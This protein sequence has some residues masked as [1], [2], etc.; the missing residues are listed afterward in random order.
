MFEVLE[1]Y[2]VNL[3]QAAATGVVN[4]GASYA[5]YSEYTTGFSVGDLLKVGAI[6]A[7]SEAIAAVT[8]NQ[9]LPTLA[10]MSTADGNTLRMY[11]GPLLSGL[12]YGVATNSVMQGIDERPFF[13]KFLFQA[14]SSVLAGYF[15]VPAYKKLEGPKYS[16]M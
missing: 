14:G 13:E 1:Q 15:T 12:I 3:L 4:Y 5:M 10:E 9:L 16:S 2:G 11:T 8:T 6:S 7:V